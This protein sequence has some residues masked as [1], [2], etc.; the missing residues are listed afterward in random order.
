MNRIH[1][2]FAACALLV[3]ACASPVEAGDDRLHVIVLHTNDIHGQVLPRKATWLKQDPAPMVGGLP[4]VAAYVER[5]RHEAFVADDIVFVVDAGD[6]YQGTPEGLLD[7]G[8]GFVRA[9]NYIGYDALCVGNH[10]FDHGIPNLKA[11]LKETNLPAVAGNLEEKSTSKRV[12]WVAPWRVVERGGFTIGFVGLVT[13]VTPEITH[14]DSRTLNFVDPGLALTRAKEHLKGKVDWIVPLTHLGVEEDRALA[15]AHPEI[16]LIVG[17]HSHTFLSSGVREGSTLIVQA[18]SKASS[19]GRVDLYFDKASKKLLESTAKLVDLDAEPPA[20]MAE[21]P[22]SIICS[23]LVRRTEERM[24]EKIG[25][26]VVSAERAKNPIASSPLGN[27]VADAVRDHARAD[28][29][30]MNRGGIRADMQAGPVTRRDVFEVLPF[31]NNIVVLKMTGAEL[32]D[33]I[34]SSVEG[35]AHS[36]IEVSGIVIDVKV[37]EKGERTLTGL[38]TGSGAVDPEHVY[39]VAM[40]SFMADGGDAYI[41]KVQPGDKRTDDPALLRDVLEALFVN[42]KTV[43]APTDNRYAVTKP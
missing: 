19:V 41:R 3:A 23:I 34:K 14:P 39:R 32:T 42:K 18:G 28:V 5:V 31:E 9:L 10:D 2:F 12:D 24:K 15:R 38:R 11:I 26:L 35:K 7:D 25:D 22:L 17:G 37:D 4:R 20:E 16:D 30:L 36:G 40:N 1:R 13:P 27:L 6:W 43:T 29:G 8:A 33:M 21:K